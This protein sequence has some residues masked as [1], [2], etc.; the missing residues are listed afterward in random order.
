MIT[1]S[2]REVESIARATVPHVTSSDAERVVVQPR[3][4]SDH[5]KPRGAASLDGE[6]ATTGFTVNQVFLALT[7]VYVVS[8]VY[9]ISIILSCI[10]EEWTYYFL[11]SAVEVVL[12]GAIV[13]YAWTWPPPLSE[14]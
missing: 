10:G 2:V 4:P 5:G 12:L 3:L 14:V 8:I 6:V 9:A 7:L 1:A 13:R 11:G